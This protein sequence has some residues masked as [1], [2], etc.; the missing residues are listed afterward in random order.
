MLEIVWALCGFV[1]ALSILVCFHEFGHYWV[2]RRVGVKVLR[3]SL[4]WGRPWKSFHT[5]D[6]VEWAIAPYPIG[7]YVKMLDERE[8]PVAATERH[9]AFNTQ[10]VPKRMAILVAGPT[11]NF[12]LAIALY[13]LIFMIGVQGLRPLIDEPRV[14]TAAAAAGLRS[15]EEVLEVDGKPVPTWTELRL[16]LIDRSLGAA[17]MDLLVRDPHGLNRNVTLGLNGVR[18]DPQ[19]LFD[20]LGLEVWQPHIDPVLGDIQDGSAAQGA[21]LRTGDRI[22]SVQDRPVHDWSELVAAVRERPGAVTRLQVQRGGSRFDVNVVL[23]TVEEAGRQVGRLGAGPSVDPEMWQNLRA[24]RQLG[25]IDAFNA[26]IAQAWQMTQLT[27]RVLWHMVLG[28]VS[29]KNVSGPIQIAQ[30]AGDSAQIGLVSFLSFMAVVSVSLGVLNLLP[31]PLL[32][33]G[34][35]LMFAIE[36]IKGRPLSERTQVAAQYVGLT[37]IGMLMVLA[38]FNDIMRLV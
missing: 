28:E 21:G 8:G 25:P 12:L 32:D 2:A 38:L 29:V 36:G 37:F 9:L 34:H 30:V 33:G 5:K 35:L 17:H 1:V 31:V 6:G 4:G 23:A 13:W 20:D 27:L 11:A 16:E 22:L 7:G 24:A 19:F 18:S 26:A 14:G 3:F 10:S 15:G